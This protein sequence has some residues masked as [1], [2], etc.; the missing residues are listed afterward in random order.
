MKQN[1]VQRRLGQSW[2][3]YLGQFYEDWDDFN[4]PTPEIHG[5]GWSIE[6]ST[7]NFVKALDKAI[8]DGRITITMND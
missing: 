1:V 6:E 4:T 2:I 3:T 5:I 8:K 7:Q